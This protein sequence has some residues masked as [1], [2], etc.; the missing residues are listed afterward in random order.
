MQRATARGTRDPLRRPPAPHSRGH[1]RIMLACV[2]KLDCYSSRRSFRGRPQLLSS[3]YGAVPQQGVERSDGQ[4]ERQDEAECRPG[5]PA[6]RCSC[7]RCR[8]CCRTR[9]CPYPLRSPSRLM[10][11]AYASAPRPLPRHCLHCRPRCARCKWHRLTACVPHTHRADPPIESPRPVHYIGDKAS[12]GP[13]LQ[14]ASRGYRSL[15]RSPPPT[16]QLG[17]RADA[18]PVVA[19][20][21]SA[22]AVRTSLGWS[23]RR[24][25]P[26]SMPLH[27]EM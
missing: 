23:R 21:V 1:E 10:P 7:S 26:S 16:L 15:P 9:P 11:P 19:A 6:R 14:K 8:W 12:S 18:A 20:Q 3:G 22:W 25:P 24:R 17:S 2:S 27:R 4:H 13:L 5:R